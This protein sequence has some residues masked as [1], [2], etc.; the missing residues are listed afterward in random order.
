LTTQEYEKKLLKGSTTC[1]AEKRLRQKKTLSVPP[2][3]GRRPFGSRF[4]L[5]KDEKWIYELWN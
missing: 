1:G 5:K 3:R 4:F 2:L